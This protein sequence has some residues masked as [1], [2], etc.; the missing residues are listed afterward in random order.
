MRK[1]GLF[2]VVITTLSLILPTQSLAQ[3]GMRWR[4]SGG[5]GT[6][7]Q[8]HRMYNPQTVETI[9]GE[10]VSLDSIMPMR[11]MSQGVHLTLKTAD[12][13]TM[14][15]HLGPRWYLENQDIDVK[16]GDNIEVT[17]SRINFAGQPTIVAAS[18][19]KGNAVL[20]LRDANGFPVWSGWRQR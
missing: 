15:V 13:Q 3:P 9:R 20:T 8:Y 11:G 19:K 7:T 6:Q 1:I 4:G 2:L 17:G 14:S 16:P 18:V 5:W 12:G 10:V